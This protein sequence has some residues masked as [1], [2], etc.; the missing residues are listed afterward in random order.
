MTEQWSD[1]AVRAGSG[2]AML[3]VGVVCVWF[4]GHIFHAIVAI[5]CGFMVWE[6]ASLL[7]PDRPREALLIG[8]CAGA[9]AMLAIYLPPGFALPLL[10]LPALLGLSRLPRRRS[11]YLLACSLVMIAGFGLMTVRDDFGLI[12]LLWL[13]GIV[14]VTDILGY[15][16][17]RLIGGPKFW[18]KVSPKKTWSGTAGGWV[19]AAI[20]G[21]IYVIYLGAPAQLIG[22]S[23]AVSM[24][25]Q[26]G[27]ISES[28]MKR[29]VGVK[30]S[31][32]L[33]PGHGGFL[34]RFDGM[35]G[36]SVFLLLASPIVGFPPALQ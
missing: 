3:A 29:R 17:G 16:A 36:A 20:I 1:L 4:G 18:P 14:V 31:S 7:A 13:V 26:V 8:T 22:L 30:D 33:I 23:V 15:F 32:D 25:S 2:G 9:V 28:A 12:W 19:G 27:D 24:A 21:G 35:L 6:L 11:T 5:V 10:F 34:D